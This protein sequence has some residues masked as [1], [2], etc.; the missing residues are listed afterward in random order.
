MLPSQDALNIDAA[1]K[2]LRAA[3]GTPQEE[4]AIRAL[5]AVVAMV[6]AKRGER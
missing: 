6:K 2:Q 1:L 5:E 4:I 3:R